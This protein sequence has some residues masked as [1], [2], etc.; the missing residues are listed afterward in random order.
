MASTTVQYKNVQISYQ[1]EQSWL[2]LFRTDKIPRLFPS[3]FKYFVFFLNWN[4]DL[5]YQ[6]DNSFKY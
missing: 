1:M 6:I 3:I 5:F 2:P 4:L